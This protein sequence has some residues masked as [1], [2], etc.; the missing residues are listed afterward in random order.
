M[1]ARHLANVYHEM[2]CHIDTSLIFLETCALYAALA[3]GNPLAGVLLPCRA[4]FNNSGV[5]VDYSGPLNA[6]LQGRQ[7]LRQWQRGAA[8]QH[9]IVAALNAARDDV[10]RQILRSGLCT[11]RERAEPDKHV[12]MHMKKKGTASTNILKLLPAA[13]ADLPSFLQRKRLVTC[14]VRG[15]CAREWDDAVPF[16]PIKASSLAATDGDVTLALQTLLNE[17][18]PVTACCSVCSGTQAREP[19]VYG[20]HA[21][22]TAA[23]RHSGDVPELLLAELPSFK[24]EL[25]VGWETWER[26]GWALS[27]EMQ[28][29]LPLADGTRLPVRYRLVAVI[30]YDGGHYACD[31]RDPHNDSWYYVHIYRILHV[32]VHVLQERRHAHHIDATL[33][34]PA[35]VYILLLL[36]TDTMR[37]STRRR[38]RQLCPRPRPSALAGI[39]CRA[40]A[41]DAGPCSLRG[42]RCHR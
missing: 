41:C 39:C 31:T 5:E 38:R 4:P 30:K 36:G 8:P 3:R 7:Q 34:P 19:V 14:G 9:E 6:W 1:S 17:R 22:D 33:C 35:F 11:S 12:Q 25:E 28:L 15:C 2:S 16:M 27:S 29:E 18:E 42:R 13:A 40:A 20:Q 24:P 37:Y 21:P 32:H 26:E 10:R 23:W